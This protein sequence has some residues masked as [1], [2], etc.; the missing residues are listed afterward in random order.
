MIKRSK[1]S[2][3]HI[4]RRNSKNILKHIHL[5]K[6]QPHSYKNCLGT[7]LDTNYD[8][9]FIVD[10]VDPLD[11]AQFRSS[12]SSGLETKTVVND[13]IISAKEVRAAH[14][15]WTDALVSISQ[16]YKKKGIEAAKALAGDV[17]DGAYAY[18]LGAVAFKPTWASGDSSFRTTREGAVSYF[19]GDN[20]NFDD[21]G[22]AI[23]NKPDPVTGERSAWEKA[24]FD[25][26]VMRLDGNTATV[27]GFM[28]TKDE[29]GNVGYV[30]KT[31]SYQKDDEG[32]VRIVLHH[33]SSPYVSVDD[34]DEL[35]NRKVDNRGFDPANQ[36]KRKEV[37]AAQKAWTNA[38]VSISQTYKDE[39]FDAAKSLAGDVI[40]GAYDYQVGPVAFKPTWAFGDTTFRTGRRGAV[41]Y[42]IG[43][44]KR[45]EDTGFG[46]GNKPDPD[47]GKRS[48]WKK[49]W[50]ENAVIRLDGDT[51]T[52]MGWMYSKDED[53]NV[54]KV[55]KT[56][57][58]RKDD[59][60]NLRI[61]VH[62]SSTPYG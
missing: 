6:L 29:D 20:D 57:T 60:G 12:K 17:I 3:R 23:G 18:Q 30:D 11:A 22:Y 35:K 36:I 49:A 52:S 8:A 55:D 40:D 46:I 53:G 26:S 50:T 9:G 47:T 21:L 48:P 2:P 16:T 59:D 56:W 5:T 61:V 34:P 41:S 19:V 62:H 32:T 44:D 33:S 45:F 24:W 4:E 58:W 51:A 38:L 15:G 42:F 25:R 39:G 14:K 27:Q 54:S 31:W 13:N 1:K 7:V 28:Y 37:K 43:G 10:Q